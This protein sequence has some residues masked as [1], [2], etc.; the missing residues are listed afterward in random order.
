M[1]ND[2]DDRPDALRGNDRDRKPYSSPQL[3][4]HGTVKDLTQG[5]PTPVTDIALVGTQ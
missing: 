1:G 4:V 2:R 5:G 3:I